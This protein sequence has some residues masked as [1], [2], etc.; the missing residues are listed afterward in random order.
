MIAEV[1][2][3]AE[4]IRER[5]RMGFA[6]A[7]LVVGLTLIGIVGFSL[8][9]ARTPPISEPIR[10]EAR[11]LMQ[12]AA[13]LAKSGDHTA[14]LRSV[15]ML[16]RVLELE[17]A[18]A[19]AYAEF[20]QVSFLAGDMSRARRFAGQALALDPDLAEA[21]AAV[22][23]FAFYDTFDWDEAEQHLERAVELD[24]ESSTSRYAFAHVL[25]AKGQHDRAVEHMLAAVE[26]DPVAAR[27]RGDAA[28]IFY[29]A[30]RFPE[31][32]AQARNA[33]KLAPNDS[34]ARAC[35]F[36]S[37]IAAG[38]VEAAARE[39]LEIALRAGLPTGFQAELQNQSA[40]ERI[41]SYWSYVRNNP[42]GLLTAPSRERLLAF[43]QLGLLEEAR[44]EF[45]RLSTHAAAA[46]LLFLSM[47]PLLEPIQDVVAPTAPMKKS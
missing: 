44:R 24:P 11:A 41:R 17:P 37:L 36:N 25:S 22:G 13:F 21:H 32:A 46:D 35:L 45:A 9:P 5:R 4:T 20:A 27:L 18:F 15:P 14:L 47:D 12:E 43:A 42:D 33:L 28:Q 7:M 39:V 26:L 19:P 10:G 23:F 3:V 38:D 8:W 30:R 31:A 16:E 6:V 1:I 34:S 29:M 2:P 40:E